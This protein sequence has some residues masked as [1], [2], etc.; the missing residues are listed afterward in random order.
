M[1]V[2]PREQDIIARYEAGVPASDIAAELS[3]SEEY[4]RGRIASLCLNL[5][6]DRDHERAMATGSWRLQHAIELA[7]AA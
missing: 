5:G 6:I 4:V 2:T 3:L 1:G 7:R